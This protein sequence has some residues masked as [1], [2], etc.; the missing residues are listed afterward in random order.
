MVI[1]LWISTVVA[2][3]FLLAEFILKYEH[4]RFPPS[5]VT[6]TLNQHSG[7]TVVAF[8]GDNSSAVK[9]HAVT[10]TSR[11]LMIW[12]TMRAVH[13]FQSPYCP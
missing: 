2:A 11:P 8:F 6:G 5:A 7:I 3:I 1:V 9:Q 10:G 13:R 12:D 4:V